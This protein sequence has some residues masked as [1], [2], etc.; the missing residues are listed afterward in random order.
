MTMNEEKLIFKG[1]LRGLLRH[2]MAMKEALQAKDYDRL[3][4]QLDE[5]IVDTQKGIED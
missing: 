5:L 1:F 3:E 2:L 4:K